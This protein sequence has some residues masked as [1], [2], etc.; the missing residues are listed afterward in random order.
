MIFVE[1]E[2]VPLI[3]RSMWQILFLPT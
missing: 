3:R 1:N 2:F